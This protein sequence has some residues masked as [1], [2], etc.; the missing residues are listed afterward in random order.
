MSV[1]LQMYIY[2]VGC[3][4]PRL[5]IFGGKKVIYGLIDEP[6]DG[7]TRLQTAMSLKKNRSRMEYMEVQFHTL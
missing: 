4:H 7:R 5:L 2:T 6:T 1:G 3:C